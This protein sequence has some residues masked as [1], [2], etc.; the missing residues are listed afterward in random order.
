MEQL[1]SYTNYLQEKELSKVTCELYLKQARKFLNYVDGR[2]VTKEKVISYRKALQQQNLSV[3]TVNLY[4]IAINHYL[5]YAGYKDCIVR[6]VKVQRKNSVENVINK[7]EYQKLL[8][9][10]KTSGHRKYYYIMKTL[11]LTGIRVSELK[12]FT[13]EVL[14]QGVI[15]VYNK[16]KLREVYLSDCLIRELQNYCHEENIQEGIIFRGKENQPI[17]RT[18]VYKMIAHLGDM[19]GIPKEKT[20]PHS[21]RHFFAITYMEHYANLAE[22]ADI[23]G[24]SSIETTRIYTVSTAEEKRHRLDQLGL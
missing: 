19:V 16:G 5:R 2:E 6:T 10:A 11:A 12:F 18:T 15:H 14:T 21:F 9:Y 8:S 24:H 20:H 17:N 1:T 7:E 4:I 23:L 22:L 13:V 3:A